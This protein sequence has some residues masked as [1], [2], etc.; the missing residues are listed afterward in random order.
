[1]KLDLFR[2]ILDQQLVDRSGT[3]MGRVDGIV[4][5]IRDGEPPV[6]DHLQLGLVVLAARVGRPALRFVEWIRRHVHVRRNAVQVVRWPLVGEIAS[7]HLKIDIDAQETEAFDWEKWLR[8][9]IVE[10]LMGGSS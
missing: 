2:D 1:M 3:K 10:K 8:T 4:L 5:E 7:H 6:V 9:H